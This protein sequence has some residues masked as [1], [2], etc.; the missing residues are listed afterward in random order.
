MPAEVPYRR[1]T[2]RRIAVGKGGPMLIRHKS[3]A[4]EQQLYRGRSGCKEYVTN[5]IL[6]DLHSI[7]KK[8]TVVPAFLREDLQSA[9]NPLSCSLTQRC[10]GSNEN[11]IGPRIMAMELPYQRQTAG[12][13]ENADAP[14]LQGRNALQRDVID[15]HR[16]VLSLCR[17]TQSYRK[18]KCGCWLYC[19]PHVLPERVICIHPQLNSASFDQRLYFA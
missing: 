11:T 4:A 1:V 15:T 12:T 14:L 13:M 9:V 10:P 18:A 7:I 3:A 19:D 17:Y 8:E 2:S 5:L 6:D 16:G